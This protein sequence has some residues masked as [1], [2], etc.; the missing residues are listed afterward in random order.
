MDT[1]DIIDSIFK[2]GL[3]AIFGGLVVF[4]AGKDKLDALKKSH[5]SRRVDLLED[6]AQHIGKV[7]HVFS[8]YASL[9]NEIGPKAAR[10]STK[11]EQEL[12]D[13]SGQLVE[14]YEEV[15]MAEAKL[16]LLGEKKLEKALKLYTGKMAQFRKQFYPGRYTGTDELSA[17]KKDT[18]AM[19]EQ[20]Y[21]VLSER[22]DQLMQ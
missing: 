16:L 20:F 22:Y 3:G 18:T 14:V 13:L 6:V 2:L 9:V 7:S 10:M 21:T 19:R 4:Y 11:Q 8:K 15:S 12:E 17:A 5:S 1:L